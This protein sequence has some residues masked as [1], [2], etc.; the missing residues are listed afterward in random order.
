MNKQN[1]TIDGQDRETTVIDGDGH[2][3]ILHIAGDHNTIRQLT[4]RNGGEDFSFENGSITAAIHVTGSS[5]NI[6]DCLIVQNR[7]TLVIEGY[8][9]LI[10]GNLFE[11]NECLPSMLKEVAHGTFFARG[12]GV[13][14]LHEAHG[15]TIQ[16]NIIRHCSGS[17]IL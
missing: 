15:N 1:L 16:N 12:F 6:T 17:G 8:R 9:N 2:G 11:N 3:I 14:T 7:M 10:M 5:N 4:F 13:I